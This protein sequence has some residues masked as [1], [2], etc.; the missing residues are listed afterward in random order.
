MEK[1][2]G[3][4][5]HLKRGNAF[6]EVHDIYM[7][8]TIDG[9]CCEISTRRSCEPSKWNVNAGRLEGKTDLART[10]NGELDLLQRKVYEKRKYLIENDYEVTAQNKGVT[11]GW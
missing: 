4:Q 10:L 5:F 8:I 7:R 2:F 3:L 6:K 11:A 1:S 9:K